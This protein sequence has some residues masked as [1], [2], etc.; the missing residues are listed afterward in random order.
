MKRFPQIRKLPEVGFKRDH[1]EVINQLSDVA[2]RLQPI[3]GPGILIDQTANG[4]VIRTDPT[5]TG[6]GNNSGK[7]RWL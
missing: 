7:P 4:M 1:A 2:A 6:N 5:F 3:A